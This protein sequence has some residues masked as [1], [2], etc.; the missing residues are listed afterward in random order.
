MQTSVSIS[1]N[2]GKTYS[3]EEMK[4]EGGVFVLAEDSGCG[5]VYF[6]VL[7]NVV[8]FV[9]GT[10]IQRIDYSWDKDIFI[11][12]DKEINITFKN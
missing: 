12:T 10:I 6:V 7:S 1:K 9:L 11:K 4:K 2:T 5:D 3:M 8:L